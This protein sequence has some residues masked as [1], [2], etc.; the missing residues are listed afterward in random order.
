MARDT[1]DLEVCGEMLING[2][3][4]LKKEMEVAAANFVQVNVIDCLIV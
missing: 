2:I 4:D 3:A 1:E